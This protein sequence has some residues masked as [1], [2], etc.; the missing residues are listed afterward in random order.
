MK[1]NRRTLIRQV[2]IKAR[3]QRDTA[4]HVS[5]ERATRIRIMKLRQS[6]A[7]GIEIKG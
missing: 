5:R 4:K 2:M 1:K 7:V 6:Q 3:N